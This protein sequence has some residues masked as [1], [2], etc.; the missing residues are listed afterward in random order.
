[1]QLPLE[2]QRERESAR[3][4]PSVFIRSLMPFDDWR[5]LTLT[6]QT[7]GSARAKQTEA[8]RSGRPH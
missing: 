2:I 1:M 7:I 5:Q 6:R 4:C 3:I 8:P